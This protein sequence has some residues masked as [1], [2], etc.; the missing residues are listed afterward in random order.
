MH[1]AQNSFKHFAAI[2]TTLICVLLSVRA[3]SMDHKTEKRKML[4]R[5]FIKPYDS[6]Q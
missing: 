4:N 5:N 3:L 2:A 6:Q 1:E